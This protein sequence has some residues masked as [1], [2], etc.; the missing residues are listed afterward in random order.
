MVDELMDTGRERINKHTPATRTHPQH[1]D[2]CPS[3]R[4][5]GFSRDLGFIVYS[6]LD[7]LIFFFSCCCC[8]FLLTVMTSLSF[9]GT[10]YRG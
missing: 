3:K 5:V 1:A 10:K 2:L 4:C 8:C 6:S 7:V 9:N